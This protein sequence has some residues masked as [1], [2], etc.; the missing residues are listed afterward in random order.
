MNAHKINSAVERLET[1][2][3]IRQNQLH[4]RQT[5]RQLHQAVLQY[6]FEH[7]RAPVA[8]DMETSLDWQE[9]VDQLAAAHIIVCD[10]K[11]NIA[12][13]YPF[14]EEARPF[15]VVSDFDPVHAMCAFDA[16][17]V[18]S[19]FRNSMRIE[20]RCHLSG[21]QIVI[22][23]QDAEIAVS[24][25]ELPVYAAIDWDAAAGASSCSA[26]LCTEMVFIV[27]EDKARHWQQQQPET[28]ELFTLAEAH[29]FICA[30]FLP[31]MQVQAEAAQAS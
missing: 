7:G 17:A 27:G 15:R 9:S 26:T 21:R 12:G 10:P 14:T 8:D 4:L 18:S 13:A 3:P 19:M 28:R 5:L 2:L 20:A 25:P 24:E 22:R 30:V 16:L 29:A 23:Q 11:G 6:F 31:L 1:N